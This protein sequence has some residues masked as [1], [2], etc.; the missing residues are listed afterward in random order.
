MTSKRFVRLVASVTGSHRARE[1]RADCRAIRPPLAFLFY[2]LQRVSVALI[3]YSPRLPA[4]LIPVRNLFF[5]VLVSVFH[6][7]LL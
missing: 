6:K 1:S 7:P 4:H 5:R 3:I 2:R